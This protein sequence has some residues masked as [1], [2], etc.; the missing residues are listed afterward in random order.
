[1]TIS[2]IFNWRR[3]VARSAQQPSNHGQG[4]A[5]DMKFWVTQDCFVCGRI[6]RSLLE[7]IDA[8]TSPLEK[9]DDP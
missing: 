2:P 3:R 5:E 8:V 1:M 6:I 7:P 9:H 4:V